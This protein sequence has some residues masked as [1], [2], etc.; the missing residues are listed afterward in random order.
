LTTSVGLI[1]CHWFRTSTFGRGFLSAGDFSAWGALA[2]LFGAL[3]QTLSTYPN[4]VSKLSDTHNSCVDIV[5]CH[6]KVIF[7][8]R[9]ESI[10]TTANTLAK[11]G[12]RLMMALVYSFK[13]TKLHK[14]S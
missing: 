3:A 2:L 13:T 5:L 1:R 11:T 9:K 6:C 14:T 12:K 8:S 4:G 10:T 7:H